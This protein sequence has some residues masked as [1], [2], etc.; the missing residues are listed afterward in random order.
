MIIYVE[1]PMES[2]KATRS[3]V[4]LA[5]L[6]DVNPYTEYNCIPIYKQQINGNRGYKENA[7]T[8]A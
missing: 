5:R 2:P 8:I 6:W 7:F 4:N 1:N 3:N